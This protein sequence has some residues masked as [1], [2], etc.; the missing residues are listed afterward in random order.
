MYL[1]R[2]STIKIKISISS[3]QIIRC[4]RDMYNGWDLQ[5]LPMQRQCIYMY[6]IMNTSINKDVGLCNMYKQLGY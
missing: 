5:L 6:T 3:G 2:A 1:F 4:T